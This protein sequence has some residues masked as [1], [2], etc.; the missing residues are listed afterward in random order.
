MNADLNNHDAAVLVDAATLV[1]TGGDQ[2]A[3]DASDLGWKPGFFPRAVITRQ[4]FGN[5][6][7]LRLVAL[8]DQKATYAQDLGLIRLYVF[9]D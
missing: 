6:L 5:G 2:Y 8:T 9:N 7:P 3:I 4:T 1:W